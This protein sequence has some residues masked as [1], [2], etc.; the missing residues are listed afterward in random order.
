MEKTLIIVA[1]VLGC[2]PSTE[3][4]P[5]GKNNLTLLWGFVFF[6]RI[7]CVN[8]HRR[9]D[10][11][12]VWN[13]LKQARKQKSMKSLLLLGLI[14]YFVHDREFLDFLVSFAEIRAWPSEYGVTFLGSRRAVCYEKLQGWN[15]LFVLN[16][17]LGGWI[18]IS[19]MNR[20]KEWIFFNNL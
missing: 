18:S 8:V 5:F 9:S 6:L 19:R 14:T 1:F 7:K 20:P 11:T 13:S 2:F 12:R 17:V 16:L 3:N 15:F 4:I 10:I